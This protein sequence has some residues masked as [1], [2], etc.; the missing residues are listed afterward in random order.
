MLGASSGENRT[1]EIRLDACEYFLCQAGLIY[2]PA[3]I[4][5]I[6]LWIGEGRVTPRDWLFL[7]TICD[8]MPILEV[9]DLIGCFYNVME[10]PGDPPPGLPVESF[11][12]YYKSRQDPPDASGPPKHLI[13]KRQWVRMPLRTSMT[14]REKKDI[15]SDVSPFLETYTLNISEGGLAFEWTWTLHPGTILDV[16]VDFFPELLNASVQVVHCKPKGGDTFV[17]G[18]VFRNL[19]DPERNKIRQFIRS[20]LH[21][22]SR[23]VPRPS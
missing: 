19:P 17:V 3:D 22:S 12:K 23:G 16:S 1:E 15:T 21:T 13:E 7:P 11:L 8:W 10:K 18:A 20:C 9:P 6:A 4:T 5:T 2:G 14:F